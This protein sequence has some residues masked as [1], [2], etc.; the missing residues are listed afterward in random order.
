[1]ILLHLTSP[2][3]SDPR[4]LRFYDFIQSNTVVSTQY[5]D[6][7]QH[8]KLLRLIACLFLYLNINSAKWLQIAINRKPRNNLEFGK[9][10]KNLVEDP[11]ILPYLENLEKSKVV[12][13]LREYHPK[14]RRDLKFYL[15]H[16][17]IYLRIYQLYLSYCDEILVVNEYTATQLKKEFNLSS[18]IIHSLPKT[19]TGEVLNGIQIPIRLVYLGMANKYRGIELAIQAVAKVEHVTLDLYLTGEDRYLNRLRRRVASI[20]NVQVK[21]MVSPNLVT[22]VLSSYDMGI[23]IYW[24]NLNAK[25]AMPNKF[26][27]FIQ[28]GLGIITLSGT[29][30]GKFVKINE[31]GPALQKPRVRQL[32]ELLRAMTIDDVESF[33]GKSREIRCCYTMEIQERELESIFFK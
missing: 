19:F 31:I 15:F 5:Y 11:L 8:P 24:K 30:M 4:P 21:T 22:E 10:D 1:L 23:L 28:A 27:Q 16:K 2:L 3:D 13:D 17:I 29:E 33:K 6:L 7:Y 26:F 12:V 18:R 14:T 20:A 25:N 9:I 32:R